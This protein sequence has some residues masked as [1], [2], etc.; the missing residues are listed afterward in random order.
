VPKPSPKSRAG[1]TTTGSKRRAGAGKLKALPSLGLAGTAIGT[2]TTLAGKTLEAVIDPHAA[3]QMLSQARSKQ[4]RRPKRPTFTRESFDAGVP[5]RDWIANLIRNPDELFE[6][7]RQGYDRVI[8]NPIVRSEFDTLIA[9][10]TAAPIVV[11]GFDDETNTLL[12]KA[13][14][15]IPSREHA[16]EQLLYAYFTGLRLVEMVWGTRMVELAAVTSE[17]KELSVRCGVRMN[18]PIAFEPHDTNRFALDEHG[19]LWMTQDSVFGAANLSRNDIVNNQY[20]HAVF[21]HPAKMLRHVYRDGD[22]RYGYGT[23]EGLW[24]Y[25]LVKAWD[26]AVA[27]WL[28]YC[29]TM[30][31]PFKIGYYDHEW[32]QAQLANGTS[33]T[34]VLEDELERLRNMIEADSYTTDARNRI[35]LLTAPPTTHENFDRLL[36]F[37]GDMIKLYISGQSST[38]GGKDSGSYAQSVVALLATVARRRKLKAGLEQTLTAQL[39]PNI[40]WFNRG[41]MRNYQKGQG[42]VRVMAP[43]LTDRER[44]E[45]IIQ[46][47]TPVLKKDWYSLLE[48]TAPTK[49]QEAAGDVFTPGGRAAASSGGDLGFGFGGGAPRNPVGM[50]SVM[51]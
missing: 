29:Q 18:L 15:S 16:L 17:G 44:M 13:I 8:G 49:E 45:L 26:A 39:L 20:G 46:S 6:K 3:A 40:C 30:G 31:N 1:A 7:D 36:M 34:Q 23:G 22:G 37:L 12:T 47:S 11:E 24:L 50:S 27:Y 41:R 35:E 33:P 5:P 14:E 51:G 25:R 19:F 42:T 21:V 32:L 2:A 4:D 48:M 9:P 28:D 43:M 38:Q 10:I